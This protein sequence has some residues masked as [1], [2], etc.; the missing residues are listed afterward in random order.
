MISAREDKIKSSSSFYCEAVANEKKNNTKHHGMGTGTWCIYVYVREQ[1]I[2]V[3]ELHAYC[4]Y[5]EET[6]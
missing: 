6:V 4:V 2:R 3:Q 5:G 1:V